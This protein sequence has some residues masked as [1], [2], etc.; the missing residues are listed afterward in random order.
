MHSFRV[1]SVAVL[2]SPILWT[3]VTSGPAPQQGSQAQRSF[4]EASQ[5]GNTRIFYWG[6]NRS[7]GQLTVDY[8]QPPWKAAYNQTLQNLQKQRWRLGQNFWTNLDTN[9]DLTLGEAEVEAGYYYLALGQNE[10]Q[11]YVL[12]V[13]DPA[14]IREQKLDSYHAWKTTGGIPV[15]LDH[16]DGQQPAQKLQI[17]LLLD[18]K[19]RDEA[20]LVIRF[21]PHKLSAPI[22]MYADA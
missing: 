8:G 21:G 22:T 18:P 1:V 9:I 16:E 3:A 19:E 12:W 2:A 15:V 17:Q 13:L 4:P 5:R 14:P 10:D 11:D 7:A 6:G 20:Q